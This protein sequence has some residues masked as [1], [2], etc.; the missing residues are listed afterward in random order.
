[1]G[2]A[3]ARK[4]IAGRP[5]ASVDDLKRAGVSQRTISEISG[6]AYAAN[7]GGESSGGRSSSSKGRGGMFSSFFHKNAG[8]TPAR[9]RP[10]A[11]ET[12]Q[13]APPQGMSRTAAPPPGT[14]MVWVNLDS[15]IY[16]YQGD[17]WYGNTKNGKYM[18][19]TDAERAGYRAA[20][21]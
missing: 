4:I 15:K 8:G 11:E 7:G 17:R 20:K 21:K 5:Y 12:E 1:V 19:E 18:S 2:P 16:H 9:S 3:T 14:G 13:P 6:R 10:T